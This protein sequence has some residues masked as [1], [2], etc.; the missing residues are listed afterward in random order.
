MDYKRIAID[1]SKH[2]FTL[3]GVDAQEHPILRRNLKRADVEKLFSQLPSTE[4]V[5]EACGGAHHW[6][7]VFAG[8]GH[9]VRL[10]PA[11]YVK[12]FVK[13]SK[14][15]RTDAAAICEAASRPEMAHVPVKSAEQQADAMILKH[16]ELLI[17]QRTATIN[18][19][20]GH[21]AEFGVIAGKGT[22]KVQP[23]LTKLAEDGAIPPAASTMFARMGEH[24]AQLDCQIDDLEKE[25][26]AQH[27]AN[28]VSQSLAAVPGVGP[29]TAITFALT[30][31]PAH[32]ASARHFAAW[33]GL[34]PKEHST[35]GKQRLGRISKEGNERLRQLLVVGA[36]SVIR[37][38]KPGAKH[39]SAW[40]LKL[41]ER[42]PR[43]LVAVALANK[44]AR[45]LWAMMAHGELYRQ[46][47]A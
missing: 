22:S 3:H 13:R 40:L 18:A 19:L 20:R 2:V 29:I 32:F 41:L 42:K 9:R 10:L 30:V 43:K 47:P 33:M 23:L 12:P 5:M 21:A 37:H 6:A 7:R 44:M 31:T 16:R 24:I 34:T 4:V 26:L 11:Q 8:L 46:S 36:T 35:G 15:D 17:R 25:L 28:S 14:N 38:A 45:I 1:I 27:K 39:T